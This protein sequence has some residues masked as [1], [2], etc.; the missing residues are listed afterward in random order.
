MKIQAF[1][2]Y[3]LLSAFSLAAQSPFLTPSPP[4]IITDFLFLQSLHPHHEGSAN[5]KRVIQFIEER[6][7]LL[8]LPKT[9]KNF[10][11]AVGMHSFSSII[12]TSIAGQSEDTAL[13]IIPLNHPFDAP[14]TEDGSFGIA[15][16]LRLLAEFRDQ[17]PSLTIKVVFLGGEYEGVAESYPG[18]T[19]YLRT[20]YPA[21]RHMV[22]Y[23]DLKSFPA[24][25]TIQ[26][27]G[28]GV[29]A[30]RWLIDHAV[31]AFRSHAVP[32]SVP[33]GRLPVFRTGLAATDSPVGEFLAAGY[34]A[35]LFRTTG[36]APADADAHTAAKRGWS[37]VM[38]SASAIT[39]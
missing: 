24:A 4:D 39:S 28:R 5:E 14:P 35:L 6:L 15:L 34:P 9:V 27:G 8:R 18:T 32:F 1:F 17:R 26:Y 29:V 2:V 33:T 25:C 38:R 23:L 3:F 10:S 16:G 20:F 19:Q 11:K 12:E 22:L 36:A 31:D 7:T 30:P 21:S 37:L 13:F